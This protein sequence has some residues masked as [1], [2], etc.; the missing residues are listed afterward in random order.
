MRN[1][2]G[3]VSKSMQKKLTALYDLVKADPDKY[4][5]KARPPKKLSLQEIQAI[6]DKY[7]KFEQ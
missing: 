7:A 2:S 3:E 6:R 1:E 4:K 5:T